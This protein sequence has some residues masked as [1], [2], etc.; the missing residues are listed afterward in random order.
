MV[1]ALRPRALGIALLL[2]TASFVT[3]CN[4]QKHP[5]SSTTDATVEATPVDTTE[6][7]ATAAPVPPVD[8]QAP[9]VV[10]PAILVVTSDPP[11]AR[12][13]VRA[14]LEGQILDA[15]TGRPAGHT[16][17]E[18]TLHDYDVNAGGGISIYLHKDGYR[19]VIG[20][21]G[22][23]RKKLAAGGKY[24]FTARMNPL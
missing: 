21:L 4:E 14:Q 19:D 23:G 13:H 22:D 17:C 11:G 12:V 20:G 24:E 10:M 6:S 2:L 3:S 7:A 18:V 9:P 8:T 1:G 15:S 5:D 16:P